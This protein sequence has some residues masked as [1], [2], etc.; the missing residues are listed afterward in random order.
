MTKHTF[1][2]RHQLLTWACRTYD[3]PGSIAIEFGVHTGRSL[4]TIRDNFTGD[5]YGFDSFEGLPETW[6]DGFPQ[7]HFRTEIKPDI[8]RTELVIGWFNETLQPFLQRTTKPISVAHLDADLYSST[9]HALTHIGPHLT[10]PAILIFDEWHNYPG[11]E[12]HEQRAFTEWI[13]TQPHLTWRIAAQV[14]STL[15][16]ENSEQIAIQ[17]TKEKP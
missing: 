3:Q 6:R 5:V 4:T 17:V 1:T 7:G 9:L 16:D 15:P 2:T 13:T 8:E 11:C 10:N 14:Q 12:Q